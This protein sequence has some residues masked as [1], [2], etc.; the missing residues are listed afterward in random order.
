[1]IQEHLRINILLKDVG[2]LLIFI[3]HPTKPGPF[4]SIR[5][6]YLTSGQM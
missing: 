6:D 1:M 4:V 2:A 3:V 5:Y